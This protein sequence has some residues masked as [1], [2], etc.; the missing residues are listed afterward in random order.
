MRI[1]NNVEMLELETMLA[2][3]SGVI[4]PLIV[5]DEKDVV[6]FDAGLPAMDKKSLRRQQMPVFQLIRTQIDRGS[7]D[8]TNF[9]NEE[10]LLC[11]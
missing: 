3:G 10:K 11:H 4:N 6:L 2:N 1:F 8:K 9:M 5:W 7:E